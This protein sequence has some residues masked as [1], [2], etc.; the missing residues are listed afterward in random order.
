MADTV[1]HLS[2]YLQRG[3]VVSTL[4]SSIPK[5]AAE[6]RFIHAEASGV[7]L[8]ARHLYMMERLEDKAAAINSRIT[9]WKKWLSS[10]LAGN[11]SA[12][13]RAAAM[14]VA[15]VGVPVQVGQL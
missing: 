5:A 3:Q 1:V 10:A 14:E 15:A 6:P 8:P 7:Q 2:A 12:G 9:A 4:N 13:G 11:Q